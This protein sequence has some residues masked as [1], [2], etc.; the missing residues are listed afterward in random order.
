M[1]TPARRATRACGESGP[2]L[3]QGRDGA[4]REAARDTSAFAGASY[5]MI[6]FPPRA[7]DTASMDRRICRKRCPRQESNLDLPLRRPIAREANN[8]GSARVC[9]RFVR[10]SPLA[11]MTRSGAIR[12]GLGSGNCAAAQTRYRR[13]RPRRDRSTPPPPGQGAACG[14]AVAA[15]VIARTTL[16]CGCGCL[17]ARCCMHPRRR[18]PANLR[19]CA[20][21][22]S[23]CDSPRSLVSLWVRSLS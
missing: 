23:C 13:H 4:V 15:T 9:W 16:G 6:S 12:L 20:I 22:R 18:K 5:P 19:R 1:A 17:P 7:V 3:S 2:T 14:Q 10:S 21:G 8:A 11:D